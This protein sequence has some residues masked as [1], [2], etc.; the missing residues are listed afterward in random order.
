MASSTVIVPGTAAGSS[1]CAA[2]ERS[3]SGST[4]GPLTKACTAA[5]EPTSAVPT[6]A[7]S[8]TAGCAASTFAL[9]CV[10][11]GIA[12]LPRSAS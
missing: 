8:R 3:S 2:Q 11:D 10:L 6:T 5:P 12:A 7:A 1:R 9:T 4:S